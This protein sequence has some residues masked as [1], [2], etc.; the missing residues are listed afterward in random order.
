M[1]IEFEI[2]PLNGG[3]EAVCRKYLVVLDSDDFDDL[4]YKIRH[5]VKTRFPGKNVKIILKTRSGVQRSEIY[6]PGP[7]A[8]IRIDP[9]MF[10]Q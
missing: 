7:A 3:W 1:D 4:I 8:P 5:W 2:Y 10:R 9:S 6:V